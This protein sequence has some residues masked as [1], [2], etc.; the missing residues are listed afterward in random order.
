MIFRP[1]A[2]L[3]C[4]VLLSASCSSDGGPEPARAEARTSRSPTP[5]FTPSTEPLPP[6][7]ATLTGRTDG[8]DGPVFA[9]KLDNTRQAHPQYGLKKA[10]VVYV[11][12]VEGGVTRLAAIYSSQLPKYVGPVRSARIS[13]IELLR[14]YGRVALVYSGSQRKLVRPLRRSKLK[15]LSFDDN[16]RGYARS[17]RRPAPYNV[18]GTMPTLRKRAGRVDRPTAVGYLFGPAPTGG[19]SARAFTAHFPAARVGGVWSASRQRW[20]LSM[21]G[22]PSM[23]AEGG[24]LGPTTFVVQFVTITGSRYRDINGA[25]TPNSRTVGRGKA[26][27]FRDGRAYNARWSRPRADKP[28]SY[29]IRGRPAV[30]AP[31]QIWVALLGKGRPVSVS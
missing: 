29:T 1:A 4:A 17:P 13:D 23:A 16:R 14:Q 25:V 24:R 8:R 10:D 15:L 6:P 26:L 22:R 28:T 2:A 18:I 11:E 7:P 19:R 27:I 12:Q 5:R 21:D 3:V 30:F 9:V 31:G 20:L